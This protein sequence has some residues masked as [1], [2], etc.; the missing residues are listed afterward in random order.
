MGAKTRRP[1]AEYQ[2]RGERWNRER[3]RRR[4]GLR[5]GVGQKDFLV[6]GVTGG[7]I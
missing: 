5:R 3:G 2:K 1:L 4:R 6:R 7:I